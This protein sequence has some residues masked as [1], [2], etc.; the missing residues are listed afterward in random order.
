MVAV[1][2]I[3]QAL[4]DFVEEEHFLALLDLLET[5]YLKE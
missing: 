5:I 3:L 1:V 4:L 2:H